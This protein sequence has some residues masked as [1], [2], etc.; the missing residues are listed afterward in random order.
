M[1]RLLTDSTS[2]LDAASAAR[3]GVEVVPLR[4]IFGDASYRDGVDLTMEEFYQRLAQADTLPTTS[5]PTPDDFLPFFQAAKEAGDTVVAVLLS[6]ELSGTVQSACIAKDLVEYDGIHLVDSRS[7][8]T[9]LRLLVERAAALR[10]AGHS[11]AE[12][13][14]ELEALKS[15]VVILAMVDTLEYLFKG[16]RLSRAG[17]ITGSLLNFK[18]IV[19]LADGRLK[20]LGKARGTAKGI[21]FILDAMK[22]GAPVDASIPVYFGYTG[23]DEKCQDLMAR[24]QELYHFPQTLVCP[25]GS[26]IGTHA[27]PGAGLITYLAGQAD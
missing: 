21:D 20:V 12:I 4:V 7:A 10:D 1:V 19:T 18:P 5:Q 3:L 11:A 25:V 9:G 6:G 22:K 26:V 14:Q 13:A 8:V 27:G 17:M 15:R 16:G 23:S 2:D 24:V